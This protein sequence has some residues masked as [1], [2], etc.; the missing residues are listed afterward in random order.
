MLS[1]FG[2]TILAWVFFRAD[3]VDHAI[4]YLSRIFSPALFKSPIKDLWAINTG[5]HIILLTVSIFL[6]VLVEWLQREKQYG[7]ELDENKIPLFI[8]RSI[9]YVVIIACYMMNGVQQEFIYF[10]F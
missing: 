1:T 2:L 3:S 10:Q 5:N 4:K 8:R 6:F 7:L 9:Y